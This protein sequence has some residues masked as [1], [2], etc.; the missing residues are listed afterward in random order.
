MIGDLELKGEF[1]DSDNGLSC[2]ILQSSSDES[3]REE[4]T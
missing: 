3:L 4:E 1:I 2:E